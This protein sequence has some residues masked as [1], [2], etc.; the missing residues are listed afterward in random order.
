MSAQPT[1]KSVEVLYVSEH[2]LWP[3]DQGSCVH[4]YKMAC[5][6]QDLGVR[7][8]IASHQPLLASAPKRMQRMAI[9]WPVAHDDAYK[10]FLDG[11]RGLGLAGRLRLARYQ[12]RDLR[13]FAGIV[14]LVERYR[15]KVVVALGQHGP[16]MLRGLRFSSST[17]RI[18]YAAD[19]PVY[20]QASCMWR[21]PLTHWPS[22]LGKMALYTALE[23]LFVRGLEGVVGVSPLD[24]RLLRW[25][26]GVRRAVTIRNG[27]DLDFFS[28]AQSDR[29]PT[30]P[31][32][33]VFWGRLDFEPNIDAVNWFAKEVWPS[34]R[35]YRPDATWQIVGKN[36]DPTIKQLT[37]LPGVELVGEV[38]DIRPYAAGAAVTIIPTRCGGG[39][40]NKLLEAAAMARPIVASPRAMRGLV[41]DADRPPMMQCAQPAEWVEAIRRLWSNPQLAESL[42]RNARIWAQHH[43]SWHRAAQMFK[44]WLASSPH[45]TTLGEVRSTT[46]TSLA[47]DRVGRLPIQAAA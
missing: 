36:P 42:S 14:S 22:R 31:H 7:V 24:T 5:A 45:G 35:W 30:Q 34:L 41:L 40:K 44:G 25:L 2:A 19:D 3:M 15:P 32:S 28:P 4:G 39:I 16:L 23:S 13:L 27:V 11:W 47:I 33:L 9:D 38:K 37:R 26:G 29:H 6:L 21:E 12:G 10:R 43:H 20:F 8:G 18:W 17:Q 1:N 46:N